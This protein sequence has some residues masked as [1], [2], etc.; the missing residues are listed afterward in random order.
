MAA[1]EIPTNLLQG[2]VSGVLGL[3]FQGVLSQQG[4]PFWKAL[5]S[6]DQL[7]SGE[8][9]FWLSRFAGTSGVQEEEPAGGA[10]TLGGSNTSYYSGEIE[11]LNAAGSLT[12]PTYWMLSVS[13]VFIANYT[14]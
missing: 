9:S 2:S 1:N 6:D 11:F 4:P 13:G 10:F 12:S 3:A 14:V 7:T 5:V 8:M